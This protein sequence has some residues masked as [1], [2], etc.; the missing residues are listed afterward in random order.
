MNGAIALSAK[1][2]SRPKMSS[3]KISGANHHF[4]VCEINLYS[5]FKKSILFLNY[6]ITYD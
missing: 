4:F 3:T 6:K 1:M 5:S 2:T